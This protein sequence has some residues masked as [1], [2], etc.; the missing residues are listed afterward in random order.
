MS[1]VVL[2]NNEKGKI[3]SI[4]ALRQGCEAITVEG[5]S[6]LLE[7]VETVKG[8]GQYRT[9]KSDHGRLVGDWDVPEGMTSETVGNN[10][11]YVIRCTEAGREYL[12]GKGFAK[13]Y[14]VGVVWS[15]A[16]RC[17]RLVYDFHNK[18]A[19]LELIIGLTEVKH[20][21]PRKGELKE[22]CPRLIQHYNIAR[23]NLM[24][25][26]QGDQQVVLPQADGSVVVGNR[27]E[28]MTL[29]D[30]TEITLGVGDIVGEIHVGGRIGLGGVQ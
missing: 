15:E 21:A 30:G 23:D 13:P 18:A 28:I 2:N 3:L 19:G 11:D 14:E 5:R 1:H 24:A 22:S 26:L 6:G 17:H 9:W 20:F 8:Q 10:A 4:A 25:G 7:V 27:G 12:R 29:P 16:D